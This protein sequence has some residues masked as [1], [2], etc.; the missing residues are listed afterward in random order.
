MNIPVLE[1]D[2][3]ILRSHTKKDF[4]ASLKMWSDPITVKFIGGKVST[5]QQTWARVLNYAGHWQLMD[6]GYWVVEEKFSGKFVGEVGFA[7]FKR[8]MEPSIDGVPELGWAIAP[9]FHGQ[10]YATEALRSVINWGDSHFENSR[11]V[12]IINPENL[13]SIKVAGKCGY[14]QKDIASYAGQPVLLFERTL[15]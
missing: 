11:T 6:F 15:D 13:V 1:T 8:E 7:D 9:E 3:L 14:V 12:C 2:R 5:S 4:S 10:G